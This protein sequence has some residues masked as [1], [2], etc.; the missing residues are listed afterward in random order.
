MEEIEKEHAANA[1]IRLAEQHPGEV[2]II[3]TGPFSNV[4]LATRLDANFRSNLKALYWMGGSVE[5]NY[6]IY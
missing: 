4:G 5:G 6:Y 3:V 2:A 1:M